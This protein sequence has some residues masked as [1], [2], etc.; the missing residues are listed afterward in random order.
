MALANPSHHALL[1][2][3]M[4]SCQGRAGQEEGL[5]ALQGCKDGLA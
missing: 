5:L 3:C 4:W 2:T 1:S